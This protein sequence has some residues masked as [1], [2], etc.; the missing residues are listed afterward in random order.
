[1]IN[2]LNWFNRKQPQQK[3]I[4]D[5]Q[6]EVENLDQLYRKGKLTDARFDQQHQVLKNH[7]EYDQLPSSL[8]DE[9]TNL[10]RYGRDGKAAK[11]VNVAKWCIE[12]AHDP[13][14]KTFFEERF[15]ELQ[16]RGIL[17]ELRPGLLELSFEL[18]KHG[19][20]Q[21]SHVAQTV[22]VELRKNTPPKAHGHGFGV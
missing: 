3:S 11:E 7:P 13:S 4:E 17:D 12:Y 5:L 14:K 6:I 2:V 10:H 20:D 18:V 22:L 19:P 9:L 15:I 1:M 21:L 8:R 16:D